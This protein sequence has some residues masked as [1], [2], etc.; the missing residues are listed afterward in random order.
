MNPYSSVIMLMK[1]G[2]KIYLLTFNTQRANKYYSQIKMNNSGFPLMFL[3]TITFLSVYKL[4]KLKKVTTLFIICNIKPEKSF[5]D[6]SK[7]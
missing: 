6:L 2:N 7:W 5:L 4:I 3:M 1:V